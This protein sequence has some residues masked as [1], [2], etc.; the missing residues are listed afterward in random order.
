MTSSSEAV[1][2]MFT[3]RGENKDAIVSFAIC[4]YNFGLCTKNVRL[5]LG[6]IRTASS[7][8][9]S[10]AFRFSSA[11]YFGTLVRSICM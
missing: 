2:S 3:S 1:I 5:T 6:S 11:L 7:C 10:A 8:E 9:K 4:R